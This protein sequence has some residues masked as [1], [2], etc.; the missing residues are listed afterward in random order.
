M[1]D[2]LCLDACIAKKL[3]F[4]RENAQQAIDIAPQDRQP[5]L[6]PRPYLR[7]NKVDHFYALALQLPG[8]P[9]VEIGEVD[10]YRERRPAGLKRSDQTSES[11]PD[12]G[13]ARDHL[14]N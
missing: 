7:R 1:P 8:E 6:A 2:K 5:S 10:E 13:Q 4:K 12:T 3:L 11:A 14:D 9:Q